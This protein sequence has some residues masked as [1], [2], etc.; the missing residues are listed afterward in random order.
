MAV[1]QTFVTE[2]PV[3]MPIHNNV[4]PLSNNKV[5][6]EHEMR[7]KQRGTTNKSDSIVK[8]TDRISKLMSKVLTSLTNLVTPLQH[9]S[10]TTAPWL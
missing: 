9:S 10:T 4:I 7:D 8:P 5:C 2:Q 3:F 1:K 6:S